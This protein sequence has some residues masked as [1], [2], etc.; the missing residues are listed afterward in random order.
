MGDDERVPPSGRGTGRHRAVR[1]SDIDVWQTHERGKRE[2]ATAGQMR[3]RVAYLGRQFTMAERQV[4][5]LVTQMA[6]GNARTTELEKDM[7][8]LQATLKDLK[9]QNDK[10]VGAI[11]FAKWLGG[12]VGLAN[13]VALIFWALKGAK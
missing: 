8:A 7:T 1:D 6:V 4:D 11:V 3:E 9:E 10:L 13:V 5:S 12:F 2:G